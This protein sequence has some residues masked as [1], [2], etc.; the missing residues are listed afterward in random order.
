V[1]TNCTDWSAFALL[2]ID[3]QRDFWSER[4]AEHFSDYPDKVTRLLAVCRAEGIEVIHLRALFQPDMS[5]W[6]VRYKLRGRIPCI[7]ST[8]GAE[9]MPWAADGPGETVIAKQTFDGFHSPEL[10][11]Y[12]QER[13]K[14][15][16]LVAGLVTS[17]CVL[18][19]ASSAMQ[20]GLLCAVV[21]DCCADE[22]IAHHETLDRYRF[23]FDRV[24]V[25]N[26]LD[27]NMDW[28]ETLGAL[29]ATGQAR[30]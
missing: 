26:I 29:K 14:R 10:S 3:V 15:F 6:M 1:T 11:Q 9:A 25:D 7:A 22:P 21:E 28:V 12:L 20:L 27:S 5:D 16:V 24:E 4:L 18:F 30:S 2:L 23:I 8:E 13:G 19:T 17:T